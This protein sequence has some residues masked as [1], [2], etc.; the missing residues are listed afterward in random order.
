MGGQEATGALGPA[1]S[2]PDRSTGI[3]AADP[4]AATDAYLRESVD[5]LAL[6]AN[7]HDAVLYSLLGPGKRLRPLLAWRSCQA[8]G[9]GGPEALPAAAAV[10]L[11]HGFS[12]VH[13]DLPAMDDDDLRRGRPTLHRHTSEAMAILAGDGMLTFG[14]GILCDRVSDPRLAARLCSELA[15]GTMGMIVGQVY[16]TLGEGSLDGSLHPADRLS[17]IHA[18]KTGALIKA[19]C[20]MGALCAHASDRTLNLI[21]R[22]ADAVG[23]MFQVVDDILDVTQHADHVGKRTGKDAGAGKLTYPGVLG[24]EAARDHV[25]RLEQEALAAAA[26]LGTAG[27]PLAELA[28]GMAVRTR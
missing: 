6:P 24:L 15:R 16:D 23:L 11:V 25:R 19:A 5:R 4:I 28:R 1:A 27:T 2:G 26:A 13:D 7:L 10:E 3:E 8:A 20:R 17:L 18:N 12:L 9:G 21:D 22:Y 14:F